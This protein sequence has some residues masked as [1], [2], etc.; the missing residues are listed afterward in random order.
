MRFIIYQS[1]A[2]L[3]SCEIDAA[4][5][6]RFA[7]K[8]PFKELDRIGFA[9]EEPEPEFEYSLII[10][11]EPVL[12]R[13]MIYRQFLDWG[14]E[15]YFTNTFGKIALTLN[16]RRYTDP[17]PRQSLIVELFCYPSKLTIFQFKK[18]LEDIS[19]ISRGLIFDVISRAHVSFGN[20]VPEK[21]RDMSAMEEHI[22]IGRLI[23]RMEPILDRIDRAPDSTIDVINE[24]RMCFGFERM[25]SRSMAKLAASGFNPARRHRAMPFRC[26]IQQKSIT[27]DTWENKQIAAFFRLV[28]S[29]LTTIVNK[30]KAQIHKIYKEREWRKI[31]P[32]G[33]VSLW[34]LEDG[35]RVE[36]L[37]RAIDS[38]EALVKRINAYPMRFDFL[39][40]LTSVDLNLTPTPKFLG[41]R[42]YSNAYSVISEFISSNGIM[43]DRGAF[44]Q[45]LKNTSKLY[46]YWVYLLFYEYLYTHMDLEVDSETPLF[47]SQDS[48]GAYMLNIESGNFAGFEAENGFRILLHYEPTFFPEYKAKKMGSRFFRST[49]YGASPL[50]PD[51]F[52]EVQSG[53]KEQPKLEY[54]IVIDCKYSSNITQIHWDDVVKYQGQLFESQ[55]MKNV[56]DQLWL[57]YPGEKP[58]WKTNYP[59]VPFEEIVYGGKS[60]VAGQLSIAPLEQ[61]TTDTQQYLKQIDHSIGKVLSI[62]LHQY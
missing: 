11:D 61:E 49:L 19:A 23:H 6:V 51:I 60:S 44:D 22:V 25:T 48:V 16:I 2:D 32:K 20:I 40:N 17:E 36:K 4:K 33:K 37:S 27:Y 26:E 1:G 62:L 43:F 42:F 35:P 28:S 30:A 57:I 13:P 52:I 34:D 7:F 29:R 38:C 56:A 5:M 10:G 46:E 53:P 59:N 9:I 12:K 45:K 55:N 24:P 14:Q 58:E 50:Q 3:L 21:I 54:G 8:H 39:S 41:D 18:M 31:A 47:R 15:A